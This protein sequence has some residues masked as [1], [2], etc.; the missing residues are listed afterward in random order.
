MNPLPGLRTV[1]DAQA[2]A[3]K[4]S[5]ALTPL[6]THPAL[7][8]PRLPP[9]ARMFL[10][11]LFTHGL[12]AADDLVR[13]LAAVGDKV[14]NLSTRERCG[15]ALVHF[16]FL[17]AY[18][19]TRAAGGQ[20]AGLVFGP[21]RVLDRLGGGTVGVVFRGEHTFLKRPVAIKV[22]TGQSEDAPDRLARFVAEARSLAGLNHPHVI[23]LHDAGVTR[24]GGEEV[25]Y[26]VLE[27]A[28][29]DL[30]AR[31]YDEGRQPVGRMAAWGWQAALGLHAAHQAGLIHRDVKPSNL[32]LTA[33]GHLKIGDF[34]LARRYDARITS[35]KSAVGSIEFFS[36]EQLDDPT[37]AGPPA[38]AYGLGVSVFWAVCGKLPRPEGLK[39]T[40]LIDHLRARPALRL[41]EIDPTL[42]AELDEL[43]ARMTARRPAERITLPDAAVAF[44]R[45]ADPTVQPDVAARLVVPDDVDA[46][47]EPRL[48]IRELEKEL[49]DRTADRDDLRDAILHGL[50]AVLTRRAGET[51]GHVRRVAAYSR[52]VARVLGTWPR[53]SMLSSSAAVSELARAATLHDLGLAGL[54]DTIPHTDDR[55]PSEEHEYRTHPAVGGQ[56]L[57]ELAEG[58]G[59]R[60]PYLRV[61]RDVVRHH[62]ER[63]DGGGFPDGLRERNIPPAARVVAVADAY[64]RLRTGGMTH[65]EA[66][67]LIQHDAGSRFDPDVADAFREVAGQ[68]GD[69][70]AAIPDD[71]T[72]VVELQA[73]AH[74]G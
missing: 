29:G 5:P 21:Y 13:F 23:G 45:L 57:D 30:E 62:H 65:D 71:P 7:D 4:S 55:T 74:A 48:A 20:W 18:Q 46:A 39:P 15:D 63:W 6:P 12:L 54:P 59:Q 22:L 16:D 41:R 73:P 8:H 60:L 28:A 32:L 25:W 26:Q 36:P 40:E 19:R 9:P 35:H 68:V 10:G 38:D 64:D 67:G 66:A 61:L 47:D 34:G 43:L 3:T 50:T 27:L 58:R 44:A 24:T 51:A 1:Q 11:E 69:L 49:H 31:V 37:A 14:P 70:F 33:A 72:A 2:Q 42:P 56:M 53:W 52:A 17:T